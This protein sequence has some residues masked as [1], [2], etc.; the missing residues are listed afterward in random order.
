[1]ERIPR[2]RGYMRTL[3]VS[4]GFMTHVALASQA[5]ESKMNV[6]E[7]GSLSLPIENADPGD[8]IME[9]VRAEIASKPIWLTVL[10]TSLLGPQRIFAGDTYNFRFDFRVSSDYPAERAVLKVNIRTDSLDAVPS[11]FEWTFSSVNGFLTAEGRCQD[12]EGGECG[13]FKSRDTV[14]PMTQIAPLGP[15]YTNAAGQVFISADTR[16]ELTASDPVV[17]DAVMTGV[18]QTHVAVDL[19]SE[20][21]F[22]RFP[23]T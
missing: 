19:T 3:I 16:L 1:M 22:D 17:V 6:D 8:F 18:E 23:A 12:S 15:Q 10:G 5:A 21:V 2:R 13:R 9:G 20:V 4:V 11:S 7:A 14:A